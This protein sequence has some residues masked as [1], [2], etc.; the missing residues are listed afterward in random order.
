MLTRPLVR[1]WLAVVCVL[2]VWPAAG[3]DLAAVVA[4]PAGATPELRAQAAEHLNQMR[5][6]IDRSDPVVVAA[7]ARAESLFA[8]G[9]VR[10]EL[11]KAVLVVAN[12]VWLGDAA[13]DPSSATAHPMAAQWFGAIPAEAERVNRR[14]RLDTDVDRWHSTGLYAVPGEVVTVRVP[15]AMI[16]VG[17]KV[18]LSGH[19]DDIRRR[20]RWDRTPL[21]VSVA[22]DLDR[23]EVQIASRFGGSVYIDLGRSSEGRG[24]QSFTILGAVEQPMFVLGR[25]GN[26]RWQRQ[27]RDRPAPYA[28]LVGERVILSVPADWVREIDDIA[29]LVR[30]WDR[31]VER[32]DA[33]G[34]MAHLRTSPERIN[35]DVQISAGLYHAGYPMQGPQSQS[36][37]LVD[38]PTLAAHGDWGWFHELGHEAQR[39]P[40][41]AWGW[42][43]PYTFDGS[44][45]CTVNLFTVH[46]MQTLGLETRGGW[47]WTASAEGVAERARQGIEQGGYQEVGVGHKLAMFLQVRDAFGWDPIRETLT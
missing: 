26:T 32:H 33:L 20:D 29:A 47:A 17:A 25:D 22:V 24:V 4:D 9:P 27:L 36:R 43:N 18:R 46:A 13:E 31:V 2:L 12:R 3:Q 39:R 5:R 19:R 30:Y 1:W 10:D 44:I 6:R 37:N 8:D 23:E 11:D 38:L 14:V 21:S 15:E 7:L 41:T 40:D 34:G 16:G 35:V 28:E 45:E 42:D